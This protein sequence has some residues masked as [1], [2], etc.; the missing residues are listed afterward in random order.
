V[1]EFKPANI[2]LITGKNSENLDVYLLI[3]DATHLFDENGKKW[4][5]T[6]LG[7]SKVKI[8]VV[9]QPNGTTVKEIRLGLF[10]Q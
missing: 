1:F 5:K 2:Q 6:E 7:M 9:M 8:E 10:S 3:G 4:S